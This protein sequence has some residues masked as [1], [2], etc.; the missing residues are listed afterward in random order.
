M[1]R[2]S[3]IMRYYDMVTDYVYDPS[4]NIKNRTFVLFSIAVLFALYL[5]IPCGLIMREPLM[6]T[7]ATIV[8]AISFTVYVIYA[9]KNDQIARAKVVISFVL[10]FLFLPSMFFTNGGVEGGTPIWLLLGTLYIAMILEGRF[11]YIML[12]L[13]IVVLTGCWIVGYYIPD[14]VVTYP[15]SGNYIDS[16]TGLIIVSGILYLMISFYIWIIS[17]DEKKKNSQRLF[18]QTATALVNAIDAKDKYTHG[19]S[20]RVAEY[21]KK[22]AELAGKT[23]EECEEIYYV[24][25]LHDVGKI[26]V[27]EAIIN[28]D[29][30]LTDEEFAKIKQHP[31]LGAQILQGITEYPYISIG[32]NFHHE[33]Y[34]GKGYPLG[35]KGSDI[36][37]IARIMSVADSYDAMTSK[38]SYRD[39]LPQDKVREELIEGSGSQFDPE[40]AS[41][42]LHLIDLDTEYD[43]KEREDMSGLTEDDEII[44][45]KHR[46]D[47][48]EG[49]LV[50]TNMVEITLKV[51]P[52]RKSTGHIPKPSLILF[53]SLDGRFHD[54]EDK[55]KSL[56]YFE[57]GEIGFDGTVDKRE[58]RKT[59]TRTVATEDRKL[60]PDEYRIEAVKVKDHALIRMIS[61]IGIREVTV[62]LPDST[63]YM[64]IGLTGTH[65]HLTD[66][67]TK[68]S[69]EAVGPDYITRIAE[70][71]SFITGPVGD[72]PNVQ[73]D[74]YR[75][76][77][78]KG[79]PIRDGMNITFHTKS[80][81]TARLVWHCPSYVIFTSDDGSVF[82]ENY[83]E[84]SLVRLD[85]EYWE[86]QETADNDQIINRQDFDGWDAWK[87]FNMNGYDCTVRFKRDGDK[88]TSVTENAGI[89]IKNTTEIKI[90]TGEIYVALS[91]DQVALTNIR[92]R[93]EL[94]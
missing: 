26:G 66:I 86:P 25:L 48:Y 27:P 82:G 76:D 55:I 79:I 8:G 6:A 51:H 81:P 45:G 70:E 9:F 84:F 85:G 28:K 3:L 35:L 52:D 72:V 11:K 1:K 65:C 38:R 13:E 63:R 17:Q 93:D 50:N 61:R 90:E 67:K 54:E 23:P 46:D 36:P 88:I 69:E 47:V 83:M 56:M 18:A 39:P 43:M 77:S 24:A 58:A 4:I 20:Q 37:E 42:M 31:T 34:D 71:I 29:G 59:E 33:R 78:T 80:L 5:A 2:R 14:I 89:A 32:A 49:I 64:Y 22:I 21:S 75:T 15:R 41:I 57:Y 53:D 92:I 7:L 12:A 74:G 60:M 44:I 73:V 87:E 19:H 10:V 94:L 68:R 40:F 16:F 30:K 62:A 91:G